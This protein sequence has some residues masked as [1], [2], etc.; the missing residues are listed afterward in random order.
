M[1]Q[2]PSDDCLTTAAQWSGLD[3]N[4]LRVRGLIGI[5]EAADLSLLG[6]HQPVKTFL[7]C[8]AI[9]TWAVVVRYQ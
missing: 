4:P 7:G 6:V 5:G 1:A 3:N 9:N 2:H 8:L